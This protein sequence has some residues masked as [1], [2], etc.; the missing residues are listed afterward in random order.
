MS[1]LGSQRPII[2]I[3]MRKRHLF[4]AGLVVLAI[5]VT[6]VVWQ[7]SFTF[8][9]YRSHQRGRNIPVLGRLH[10]D[11]PADGDARLHAVPGDRQA[12]PG[13]AAQPRRLAHPIEAGVWRA[14]AELAPG[15]VPGPVQ[16]RG[17]ESQSRQM[18]QRAGGRHEH[19]VAGRRGGAGRRGAV[20][21]GCAGALAGGTSRS[22]ERNRGLR[23]T[24]PREPDRGTADRYARGESH[25]VRL[26]RQ[27]SALHF[28]RGASRSR[29]AG[30]SRAASSRRR[31]ETEAD[32]GLREQVQPAFRRPA[33]LA[34]S[35]SHVPG[36]DRACSS[37]SWRPGS[38]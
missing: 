21:G 13:A 22:A 8:G 29:D 23:Q 34:L 3:P 19:P 5:L 24:V 28:S 31:G 4:A 17:S 26:Q 30:G 15:G 9:E 6:L 27:C 33:V 36:V 32:P 12:V 25:P 35:V 20:A 18:V 11:F 2:D 37:C 38:R 14:G 16:L 1:R 10:A 7:V